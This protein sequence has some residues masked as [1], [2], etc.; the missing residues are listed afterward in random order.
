MIR[1]YNVFYMGLMQVQDFKA[2]VRF[3]TLSNQRRSGRKKNRKNIIDIL[4]KMVR[5][6][7]VQ[8]FRILPGHNSSGSDR[9]RNTGHHLNTRTVL[10]FSQP[11]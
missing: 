10:T 8:L 9:T 11:P 5:S 7:S 6:V 4:V 3:S 1:K 2:L